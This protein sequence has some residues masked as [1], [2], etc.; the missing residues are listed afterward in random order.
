[1]CEKMMLLSQSRSCD[2]N[3]NAKTKFG[4]ILSMCSQDIEW[5]PNYD[6]WNDGQPKS[7]KAQVWL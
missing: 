4:Q 2:A 3:I 5:K 7:S 1:M 6:R